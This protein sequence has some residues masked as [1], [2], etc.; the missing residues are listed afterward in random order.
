M[1]HVT[2]DLIEEAEERLQECADTVDY[3]A[4][5]ICQGDELDPDIDT[6]LPGLDACLNDAGRSEHLVPLN[7]SG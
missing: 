3:L 1:E 6:E 7:R 2:Q 4:S 5:L